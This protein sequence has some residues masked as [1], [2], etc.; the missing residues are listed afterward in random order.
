MSKKLSRFLSTLFLIIFFFSFGVSMRIENFDTN[1]VKNDI[2]Y[3]S[4]KELKGRLAGTV[5]NIQVANFIKEKFENNNLLPFN[6]SYYHNFTTYYPQKLNDTPYLRVLDENNQVIKEFE[7][8]KDYKEDMINFKVNDIIF[9]KNNNVS[10]NKEFI[11]VGSD[12]GTVLLYV[13]ENDNMEFRS[14]FLPESSMDL[15]LMI[16]SNTK[17]QI[18][19]YLKDGY[20]IHCYIPYEINKTTVSNVVGLIPGKDQSSSPIVISAHFDHL[21]TDL[22]NTLYAG[23]LDNAS[24]IAF[25]ME[26]SRYISS[27]GQP[28][29]NILFIGFNAEE[30]GC[31]G[32]REFVKDYGDL[33]KD[34]KVFNF[35]MIG[36]NNPAPLCIMGGEKDSVNS[37]LVKSAAS[38][39]IK[40]NIHFNYLFQD[41][42]DH[43]AFRNANIE[44]ITFIDNDLSRIHTPNDKPEFISDKSINRC[45]K[46]ASKELI[47]HAFANNPLIIYNK[48]ITLISLTFSIILFSLERIKWSKNPHI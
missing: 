16:T 7:Y 1:N 27:L 6:N 47:K 9:D 46:V 41:S 2:Q 35:D 48:I 17:N 30:F 8:Y 21:G 19:N 29:K 38:A 14:S 22:N 20:K 10:L 13:A 36:T 45:F 24:G 39:C 44:A 34:S 43:E 26:M 15:Y 28:E 32:A 33:L 25:I 4:S 11:A 31:L 12:K 23:A 5:E 37:P 42:S 3:L 18:E 40:E